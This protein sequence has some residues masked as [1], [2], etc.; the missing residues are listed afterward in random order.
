MAGDVGKGRA[1]SFLGITTFLVNEGLGCLSE[2]REHIVVD[3]LQVLADVHSTSFDH[4][5]GL[6]NTDS[7]ELDSSLGLD[8]LN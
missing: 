8:L 1:E 7:L 2:K 3:F 4:I 5:L 6:G